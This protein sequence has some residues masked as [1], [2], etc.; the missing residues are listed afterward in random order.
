MPEILFC[1]MGPTASGK[2]ALASE[3]IKH[4]P[5]EIISVD[6]AMVYREMNI[7]TAK[8][9]PEELLQV[10]HHLIDIIDPTES[11]SA[12][13][14]CTDV[15]TLCRAIFTRGKIPLLVGGTMM[16]FNAL[17][18]GLSTLPQANET[19][20]ASLLQQAEEYGW[21]YLHQQL[22]QIDPLSAARIHPN[23]TQR[24]QRA[25]EVYQV[26]GK[27][28]SSFWSEQKEALAYRFVNLIL[29][30][31]DRAWLHKRI[32]LRFEQML[33]Q[34]FVNEVEQ[35]LQKWQLSPSC[36][37]MRSV[38]YRQVFDYLAG[39]YDFETLRHKGVVATR[40]LAKRQLTWLRH[41]QEATFFACENPSTVSEIIALINE[42]LDNR[43]QN[44]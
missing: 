44:D 26:S 35:L 40:Q 11:Y 1:L 30:P 9:T 14:F 24:I 36:P 37:A 2:T 5:F 13:Q 22:M 28:L 33:E 34:G 27:P 17:Q 7:G 23:D 31:E 10:P 25:L 38:G 41:W 20:R 8:P 6:S 42:I 32:A 19:I 18:Q 16:Y 43:A 29:F 3:L 21:A 39:D 4:F 12:A 15:F